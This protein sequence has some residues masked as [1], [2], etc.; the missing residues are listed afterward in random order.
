MECS[1]RDSLS[2]ADMQ[3]VINC[4]IQTCI[5]MK[6]EVERVKAL[7]ESNPLP[8]EKKDTFNTEDVEYM[9]SVNV[10]CLLYK[11]PQVG[12]Q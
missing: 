12:F 3:S 2:Q 10:A 5:A 1:V 6:E 9:A 7:P 8:H 11:H 4:A